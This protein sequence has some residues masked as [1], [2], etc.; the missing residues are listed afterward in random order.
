MLVAVADAAVDEDAVVVELGDA[1]LADAAVLGTRRFQETAGPAVLAREEDGVV[2]G[3]EGHVVGVVLW[4]DVSRVGHDGEVEEE[5]R[6]DDGDGAGNS[7]PCRHHR[8]GGGKIKVLSTSE[9]G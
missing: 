5:V 2:V 4:G 9:Q 6:E 3:I 7:V 8:P 1:A